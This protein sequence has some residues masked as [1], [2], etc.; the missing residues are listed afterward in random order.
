MSKPNSHNNSQM[1][2]RIKKEPDQSEKQR[3]RLSITA[4]PKVWLYVVL[5]L[6]MLA[7]AFWIGQQALQR[8]QVGDINVSGIHFTELEDVVD[9]SGLERGTPLDSISYLSVID[10]VENLPYVYRADLDVSVTG[11]LHV[12]VSE[13]RPIALL[14]DDGLSSYV[15][16]SG[17]RLPAVSGKSVDVPLLYLPASEV[18]ADSVSGEVFE[19]MRSFLDAALEDQITYNTISEIGYDD[20]EGVVALSDENTVRMV[21]GHQNFKQRISNWRAFHREII[22]EKGMQQMRRVDMRFENQ[23]VTRER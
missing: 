14:T 16:T 11:R 3:R 18:Q 4:L 21:F 6:A 1:G 22:P 20:E 15:D 13:R 19:K 17:V 2:R 5:L 12:R 7:G 8:A 10:Q 23:I 9:A